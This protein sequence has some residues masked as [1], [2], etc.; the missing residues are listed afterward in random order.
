MQNY[1]EQINENEIL[2]RIADSNEREYQE[3]LKYN[4]LE[5][6]WETWDMFSEKKWNY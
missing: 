5:Q 4:Q 3:F 6:N 1:N 2:Q